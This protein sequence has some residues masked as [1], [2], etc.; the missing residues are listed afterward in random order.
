MSLADI[1]ITD[2]DD[3]TLEAEVTYYFGGE[4]A[5]QCEP[6]SGPEIEFDL[7]FV[8]EAEE[9]NP[10]TR[11]PEKVKQSLRIKGNMEDYLSK[12][13]YSEIMKLYQE[14]LS[15]RLDD[16]YEDLPYERKM[17]ARELGVA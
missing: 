8:F 13:Y 5:T 10:D 15:E 4:P 14:K 12:M 1:V 16:I 3:F 9:W 11:K 17:A 6:G 2:Y 7:F